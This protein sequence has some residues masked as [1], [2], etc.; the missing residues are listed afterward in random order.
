MAH[1]YF[2]VG[3]TQALINSIK[4]RIAGKA[5]HTALAPLLTTGAAL[6]IT[7]DGPTET[8]AWLQRV[9]TSD[10]PTTVKSIHGRTLR[11]NQLRQPSSGSNTQTKDGLSWTKNNDG[12]VVVADTA[13]ASGNLVFITASC[14]Q[15]HKYLMRGCSPSGGSAG[16]YYGGFD[17]N[18][19]DTGNG[20]IY[21]KSTAD[22]DVAIRFSYVSGATVPETTLWPQL[23]DLTAMFGAGNEPTTVEEFEA[24]YPL[25]YYEYDAGSLLPV[26]MTGI[27]TTGFNQWD[28][29]WEVGNIDDSTGLDTI[30]S[31]LIRSKNYIPVFPSTEYYANLAGKNANIYCYDA[32]KSFIGYISHNNNGTFTTLAGTAYIRFR[33]NTAYGTTYN[34]DICINLSDPTRNGTYE[35]YWHQTRTVPAGTLRG[36]GS[37]FDELTETER[38]TRVGEVDLGTLTWSKVGSYYATS[39]ALP[40]VLTPATGGVVANATCDTYEVMASNAVS[41]GA[42]GGI[43]IRPNGAL[44]ASDNGASPTGTLHYALATPTVTP[45]DPPL[46]LTYRTETGG[47]ERVIVPTGEQSAPPTIVTAQ[48]YTAESLR[49]AALS[50]IAPVENGLA[51]ANYAVG[52]YLVHGGQLCR[53]TTAI[54]TGESISIGTN[55]TAT[56]VMAEILSL[57]Q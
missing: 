10:G 36:A 52:A 44:Y 47:T 46:N 42:A 49:D 31:Q 32:A 54:A 11:W 37:V 55:V 35:P 23:F 40:N 34:N 13:T 12:S 51:S 25:P 53:V 41:N 43:G 27:E 50:A 39:D 20:G 16:T 4:S 33:M 14:K 26:N 22:S 7:G 28:E 1:E 15:G 48:G 29:E 6:G 9:S 38:I 19:V 17:S 45:Y 56:T 2:K 3:T 30:S 21:H 24:L 18:V 57:V 5:D 8:A